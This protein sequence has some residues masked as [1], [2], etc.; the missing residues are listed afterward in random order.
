MCGEQNTEKYSEF[1]MGI[2]LT[3]FR[4]LEEVNCPRNCAKPT[5]LT[6]P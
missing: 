3:T 4:T 2:E 6:F 5:H 1:Q